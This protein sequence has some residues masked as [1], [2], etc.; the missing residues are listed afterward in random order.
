MIKLQCITV[1]FFLFSSFC[2]LSQQLINKTLRID[3]TTREYL[4]YL[5]S[6]FDRSESIPVLF[7]FHGRDMYAESMMRFTADFRQL[8][9]ANQFIA[10]YPQGLVT[11]SKGESSTTWNYEGPYDN[12]TDEIGFAEAMIDDLVADHSADSDRIYACGF[13]QGG[14]LMWDYASLLGNRFAAIASVAASM[15]EWTYE[16]FSPTSRTGILTIHGTNDS[17]NP[18]NGNQYSISMNQLNEYW[19]SINGSQSSPS[20]NQFSRNVTR[21]LWAEAEGCHTVEHYRVQEGF[22]DWPSFSE[23]VIWDFV[24]QYNIDGLIGCGDPVELIINAYDSSSKELTV[25]IKN[26]RPGTFE[27]RKST[28]GPFEP[29][30]PG[31]DIDRNVVFP[32]TIKN[33]NDE[34]LLLQVWEKL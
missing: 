1:F 34:A 33:V 8:A 32:L 11:N 14:N 15:W 17:Y 3:G 9:D 12:G 24:S 27:L 28:G 18:Y 4:V 5:P 31:L 23:Q 10:V 30:R 21:Y 20:T 26:L 29:L 19:V 2:A 25:T 13:S 22:H 7:C 16:D 6:N